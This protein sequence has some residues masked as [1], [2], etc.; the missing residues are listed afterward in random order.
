MESQS[1]QHSIGTQYFFFLS[2]STRKYLPVKTG[3]CQSNRTSDL[4]N[5]LNDS[6]MAHTDRGSIMSDL[7]ALA[8]SDRGSI[9]SDGIACTHTYRQHNVDGIAYTND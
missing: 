3:I 1:A 7:L 6:C 4:G 2:V 5:I 9:M 8:C